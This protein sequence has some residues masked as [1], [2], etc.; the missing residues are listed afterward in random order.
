[1]RLFLSILST[2]FWVNTQAQTYL[3]RADYRQNLEPTGRIL[4]GAGQ[5]PGQNG[6]PIRDA[7]H[8]YTAAMDENEAPMVYMYYE[9]LINIGTDWASALRDTLNPYLD[10]MV[11][12]QF[13]LELVGLTEA[14]AA[15]DMDKEIADWLDGIEDLGLPIY[16]RLGYEFNGLSWNGYRPDPYKSAFIYLTEKIRERELEIATVWNYVPDPTQPSDFMSYYPGDGYVD[17]W[18]INFFEPSQITGDLATAFLDSAEA[19]ARPVLIGE[20]TPKGIGVLDGQ[21]SW[22]AWFAPFFERIANEP[23]LKM[24]GYINWD[25]FQYP[26][27]STW[28]DARIEKNEAVRQNFADQMDEPLYFH[29]GN[30]RDFRLVLGATEDVPPSPVVNLAAEDSVYPGRILWDAAADQSG[31]SRYLIYNRNRLVGYTGKTEYA[32]SNFAGGSLL[33]LSVS[34]V[35]RAGNEGER[36]GTIALQVPQK[37]EVP[38]TPGANELINGEFD[39]GMQGWELSIFNPGASGTFDIDT[40]GQLSGPNS[41]HVTLLTNT[42]TN[43][44]IQL[45]QRLEVKEGRSYAISYQARSSVP[46]TMETWLQKSTSPFTGYAFQSVNLTPT[47]RSYVDTAFVSV[48]DDVL[49]RFMMG[50]SGQAEIWIDDVSIVDLSLLPTGVDDRLV[51]QATLELEEPYPNPFSGTVNLHYS[52]PDGGLVTI[53]VF[54]ILGRSITRVLDGYQKPGKHSTTWTP[55]GLAS[56]TYLVELKT[57]SQTVT[58]AV[59]LQR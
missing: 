27:W 23:G 41:A 43:F 10:R 53:E 50:V 49:I 12:I 33:L 54:D 47:G 21:S 46:T 44:H 29:A 30:E 58:R 51:H 7:F 8:M 6:G 39:D 40:T 38:E 32:L 37:P 55:V 52:N 3:S 4:H 18:S 24:T 36:S 5:D 56:G 11:V 42:G 13:G 17:W 25:W 26:Q 20:S 16:A 2:L 31:I 1:M 35:D 59:V 15:G 14:I 19:H 22:D 9:S 28:G 57:G 45:E 48:D 34:A